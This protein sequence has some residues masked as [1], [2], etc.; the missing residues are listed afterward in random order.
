[1]SCPNCKDVDVFIPDRSGL[2][3]S[4]V[5]NVRQVTGKDGR[6]YSLTACLVPSLKSPQG[7]WWVK[8]WV[9]GHQLTV[10]GINPTDTFA[11]AKS[12]F[13]LNEITVPDIDLWINLNIQWVE[14]TSKKYLKVSLESILE[15]VTPN[16]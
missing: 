7:G 16:Y 13:R 6:T 15:L 2:Q 5:S 10:G 1:M 8:L 9:K 3:Y 11:N 14:R 12:L 4:R